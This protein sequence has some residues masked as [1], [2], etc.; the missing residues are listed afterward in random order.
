MFPLMAFT[1]VPVH[2]EAC[3]ACLSWPAVRYCFSLTHSQATFT[4]K[5]RLLI[6][7]LKDHENVETEQ[8]KKYLHHT[9]TD[10][11]SYM[12][13]SKY[14]NDCCTFSPVHKRPLFFSTHS[15]HLH[16]WKNMYKM[17]VFTPHVFTHLT[18]FLGR[19]V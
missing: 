12:A 13:C 4:D 17:C 1:R 2:N 15:A 9:C 18:R 3:T 10:T 11:P 8:M 19:P 16:T 5:K 6:L 14:V 7:R